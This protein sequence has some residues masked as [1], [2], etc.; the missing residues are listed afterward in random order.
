MNRDEALKQLKEVEH[1]IRHQMTPSGGYTFST[2]GGPRMSG[3]QIDHYYGLVHPIELPGYVRPKDWPNID[4]QLEPQYGNAILIVQR[5]LEARGNKTHPILDVANF[6]KHRGVYDPVTWDEAKRRNAG[7]KK[8]IIDLGGG[9]P[10]KPTDPGQVTIVARKALGI[11][12][13]KRLAI[14]DALKELVETH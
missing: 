13:G 4:E 1:M 5:Y 8:A 2:E 7:T 14:M 9:P 12:S 11:P 3:D 6:F 10:A